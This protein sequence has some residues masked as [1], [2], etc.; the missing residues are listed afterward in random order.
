MSNSKKLWNFG[1]VFILVCS[2]V[3]SIAFNMV[4]PLTPDFAVYMGASLTFAGIFTGVF[5]MAALLARPLGNVLG[6]RVNKKWMLVFA[7]LANGAMVL[8]YAATPYFVWLMPIRILHGVF[9][10]ICVTMSM[11]IIVNFIPKERLGEGIGYSGVSFL[12]GTAF[13]PNIGIFLVE[14]FSFH[15]NFLASGAITVLVGLA[16]ILIPYSRQTEAPVKKKY[17]FED[18]IAVELLPNA[19][20]AALLTIG[21]GLANSYMV[22]LG[23]ERSIANIGMYFVLSSVVLL[24]SRP[25]LGKLTDRKGVP[26]VI[27]PSFILTAA[28]LVLIGVSFSLWLILLAGALIALGNGGLPALQ[29][30]SLRKLAGDRRTVATGTYLIGIDLGMGTGQ[31]LG[32]VLTESFSFGT[33][34]VSMGVFVFVGLGGYMLYIRRNLTSASI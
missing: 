33:V 15:V 20:F 34:F 30:D 32:G 13:G 12:L 8:F 9:F 27:I 19:L 2:F 22:M 21:I 28:G 5:A 14:H 11:V 17:R 4:M 16:L 25:Y 7:F 23:S 3:N 6:D 26:F 1:F 24:F 10:S 31:T 29:V 18:F